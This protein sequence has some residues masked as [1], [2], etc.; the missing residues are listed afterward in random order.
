MPNTDPVF[1]QED[2][3]SR[4]LISI[5]L[6]LG[7]LLLVLLLAAHHVFWRDEVRAL[8]FGLQAD[9]VVA[10]LH[11]VG[12]GHPPLWHL[13]LRGAHALFD[14]PIVLPAVALLVALCA[15]VLIATRSPFG[16]P[17]LVVF[18]LGRPALYEYSVMARNYGISMLLMFVFSALYR[19]YR[20]RGLALGAVLFMLANSN[21]HSVLLV[22]AFCLFWL[23][24]L[25]GDGERRPAG[26]LRN[27]GINAVIVLIGVALCA[28]T[29]YPPTHDAVQ[30]IPP[31]SV[32]PGA[33]LQSILLPG[34]AFLE[35]SGHA[36]WWTALDPLA[37]WPSVSDV[38]TRVCASALL[39]GSLLGLQRRPAAVVAAWVALIGMSVFF[40]VVYAGGYRHQALWLMFLVSLYWIV[41]A[42]PAQAGT[43]TGTEGSRLIGR[44]L[45]A[46]LLVLQVLL[47]LRIVVP[48]ATGTPE[49][50]SRDLAQ[51]ISGHPELK[52]ATIIADP[53]YL[54]E[55]LPY[56]LS[57][58]TYLLRERRFGNVVLFTRDAHSARLD[59]SIGDIL[60]E[61]KQLH[62][63]SHQPVVILLTQRIS[64]GAPA[65]NLEE[66]YNWTLS[67]S[68]E[69]VQA[70]L[71]ST[72]RIARFERTC[73]TDENFD[74][75]VLD[76]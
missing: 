26:A 64:L 9:S 75:Y 68:P 32:N 34:G 12:D 17:L 58:P 28:A 31:G 60:A 11:G 40:T 52:A 38:A 45:F 57:N 10:L 65:A 20:D 2:G 59:L 55:P 66:G 16:W 41:G 72:R 4:R 70:F 1:R 30:N 5:G 49:S 48:V 7:W 19:R 36:I 43:P 61:A 50:R 22:G 27:F 18:L 15:V 76:R 6:V 23:L 44:F 37:S 71:S 8:S 24:D 29:I 62:N 73:C 56:Y 74:V 42:G 33:L 25:M 53:D 54:V 51:L 46:S 13:I 47:G 63:S 21:A 35:L 67:T 39:I 3:A 69:A 14:T